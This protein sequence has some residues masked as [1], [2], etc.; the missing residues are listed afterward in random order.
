[1]ITIAGNF[2]IIYIQITCNPNVMGH[3]TIVPYR[4]IQ[5]YI[6]TIGIVVVVEIGLFDER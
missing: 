1:M 6:F 2:I 5:N 3:A 4:I